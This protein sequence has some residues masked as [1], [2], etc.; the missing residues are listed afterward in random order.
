MNT[1][2]KVYLWQNGMLMVF[3]SSGDQISE[4]QGRFDSNLYNKVLENSN[5][6]TLWFG[7]GQPGPC[8]WNPAIS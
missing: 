1:A 7:F 6:D 2:A 4:L 3:D 8:E 5:E